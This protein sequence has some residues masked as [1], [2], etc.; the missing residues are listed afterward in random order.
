M[1]VLAS[2]QDVRWATFLQKRNTDYFKKQRNV[3]IVV[4]YSAFLHRTHSKSYVRLPGILSVQDKNTYTITLHSFKPKVR[5]MYI[6]L[7]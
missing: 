6:F 2:Y 7:I 4:A 5:L 3:L 1:Q